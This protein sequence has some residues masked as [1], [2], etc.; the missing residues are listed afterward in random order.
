MKQSTENTA[1]AQR[2]KDELNELRHSYTT[3][4][5]ELDAQ[6]SSQQQTM[7]SSHQTAMED[8]I[9][10]HRRATDSVTPI[11]NIEIP[12]EIRYIMQDL[13]DAGI[14]AYI[15]GG[16]V[17]DRLLGIRPTGQDDFDIIINASPEQ[18]PAK[19]KRFAK[20]NAFEAC[21]YKLGNMDLWCK[22]W[23]NLKDALQERDLT[24]NTFISDID[25]HVFDLLN[26]AN[27]LTSPFLH[28]M[29]DLKTRFIKDPSLILRLLRF[30]VQL[31]KSILHKD[32]NSIYEC[33]SHIRNLASGIYFKNI[34]YLFVSH[35]NTL[36]LHN[37]LNSNLLHF[38]FPGIVT[39]FS[40]N[41]RSA[42]LLAFWAQKLHHFS[43]AKSECSFYHVFA[44]FMLQP[45]LLNPIPN[46]DLTE[47]LNHYIDRFFA[48]YGGDFSDADKSTFRHRIVA[49]V[50]SK[51]QAENPLVGLYE[52]F[53][54]FESAWLAEQQRLAA[55]YQ[56][57]A[58]YTPHFAAQRQPAAVPS[59]APS[60][61]TESKPKL[62]SA[63]NTL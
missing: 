38:V 17:R 29:G 48:Q 32:M 2:F 63:A 35:Y 34:E 16:Y 31:N 25:G 7:S 23:R 30:S 59:P 21:Q 18:L 5:S 60:A 50:L 10:A 58:A 28:L 12:T 8:V 9:E 39:P 22:P 37:M 52:Q 36:H 49:I 4:L 47:Q 14:E 53:V 56:G 41:P 6:Q 43:N 19:L 11:G 61:S 40:D 15:V 24:I 33:A 42:A 45:L 62:S 46:K 26:H 54:H 57:Q 1:L 3:R 51:V 27:D 13:A 44:L 20:Q 55:L